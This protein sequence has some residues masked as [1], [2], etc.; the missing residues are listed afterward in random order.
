M[1]TNFEKHFQ[2]NVDECT[3]EQ[4]RDILVNKSGKTVLANRFRALFNLKTVAEEFA[5]KPEE[6]KRPSNTLPN[7][8]SMTSLSC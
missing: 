7:P 6:A 1:S 4:L 3:L 5:T 2:E 8:S